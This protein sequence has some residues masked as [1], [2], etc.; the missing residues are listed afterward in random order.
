MDRCR[1]SSLGEAGIYYF[2]S[3]RI[4]LWWIHRHPVVF[5]H[6]VSLN[7]SENL[8]S[9]S[10]EFA[11][12]VSRS[13]K[14]LSDPF[15]RWLFLWQILYHFKSK[16][17]IHLTWYSHH[18]FSIYHSLSEYTWCNV[19]GSIHWPAES[20]ELTFSLILFLCFSWSR[21]I[22]MPRLLKRWTFFLICTQTFLSCLG[23]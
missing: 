21:I 3:I 9:I 11:K 22:S 4:P 15:L 6:T 7:I 17:S 10:D 20:I 18:R 5:L 19:Q 12:Q 23:S 2:L 1:S 8:Y 13:G 16:G 14:W